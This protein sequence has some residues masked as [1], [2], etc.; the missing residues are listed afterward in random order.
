MRKQIERILLEVK[1]CSLETREDLFTRL[2]DERLVF[3][4]KSYNNDLH[5][6]FIEYESKLEK[7]TMSTIRNFVGGVKI[8]NLKKRF[9]N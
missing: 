2:V 6:K 8:W 1:N 9:P 4:L 3:A 7:R 5:N